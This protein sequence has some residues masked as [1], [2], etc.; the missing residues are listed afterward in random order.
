[1]ASGRL[2][3]PQPTLMPLDEASRAHKLMEAGQTLGKVVLTP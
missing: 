1:M 3:P 2:R